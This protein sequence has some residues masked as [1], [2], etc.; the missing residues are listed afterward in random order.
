MTKI[1]FLELSNFSSSSDA[2]QRAEAARELHIYLPH[3]EAVECLSRLLGD[4]DW[5]VRRAAVESFLAATPGSWISVVFDCL[6]DEENAGKRNAAITVLSQLGAQILPYL[7]PHLQSSSVDVRMFLVQ[8]LGELQDRT[9]LQNVREAMTESDEN[10]VSAAIVA[11]G[12]IGDVRAMPSILQAME[13]ADEWLRFQAIEAAGELR[14]PTAIPA[15][16]HLLPDPIFRNAVL[17]V[18]AKLHHPDSYDALITEICGES[19][20]RLKAIEAITDLYDSVQPS[21]LMNRERSAIRDQWRTTAGPDQIAKLID[22]FRSQQ[23]EMQQ[24]ILKLL[25]WSASADAIDLINESLAQPELQ[26]AARSALQ[27]R[28]PAAISALLERLQGA[29]DE[30]FVLLLLDLLNELAIQQTKDQVAWTDQQL[31]PLRKLLHHEE[32]EI[33]QRAHQLLLQH[34]PSAEDLMHGIFDP[35]PPVQEICIGGLMDRFTQ[36]E[37]TSRLALEKRNSEL[38]WERA[39]AIEWLALANRTQADLPQA[40]RDPEAVVRQKSAA[41]M[42]KLQFPEFE[43]PLIAALADEDAK[44]RELAAQALSGYR[45]SEAHEGLLSRLHDDQLWVRIAT[46]QSLCALDEASVRPF[47]EERL[48]IEIPP[49][50]AAILNCL[51]KSSSI[52]KF[53][54]LYTQSPDVEVRKAACLLAG[55][56]ADPAIVSRMYSLLESDPNWPVRAAAVQALV[57]LAPEELGETL[58]ERVPAEKEPMVLRE[59]LSALH[60]LPLNFFPEAVFPLLI[61]P[62]TMDAA[63]DLLSSLKKRMA[64]SLR[65]AADQQLPEI[66]RI[67]LTLL[68]A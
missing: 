23:P 31:E 61:R 62:D 37:A 54:L 32:P 45:S 16:L 11:L 22:D 10:L 39:A 42:G 13:S 30:E 38:P 26:E 18:L 63:Y 56:S 41:L 15:L 44:V 48:Q 59:I 46:Y 52:N 40:L 36:N 25:G 19:E 2:D 17:N 68:K 5:R 60:H 34:R 21:V 29:R 12:K 8:I 35:Y 58:L 14:D 6:Y 9:Y 53:I 28:G 24:R 67:L 4:E 49:G 27:E 7:A 3:R 50:Q 33:R 47:L 20:G 55:A 51:K 57:S 64:A 1:S 66:R 43:R 65:E